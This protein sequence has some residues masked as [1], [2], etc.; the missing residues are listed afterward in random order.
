M[1][2]V[3]LTN[4]SKDYG[5]KPL[6]SELT[7]HIESKERLGII[8]GNGA[9]KSTLLNIIA[10]K[11]PLAD[12]KR[13]AT[14]H[15]SIELVD[16]QS[17][18]QENK[19]IL[20]Q[21]LSSC[22]K[23]RELLLKFANLSKE[24][25]NNPN[26]SLCLAEIGRVSQE[27]DESQAW[28][29][30]KQCQE[31]LNRLGIIEIH[32]PIKE[33]SGGYRKR[34]SLASALVAKP[35]LLLLDEPTNHL[36]ASAV[37]WLQ[38]WLDKYQGALVI[39]THDR[40][41]LDRVTTRMV[42]I[43]QG[44]AKIFKGNYNDFLIRKAE[45]KDSETSSEAKFKSILRKEID[46]LRQGP[47]ARSTKQKARIQRI[48]AMQSQSKSKAN[49]SLEINSISRR[50]GKLVIEAES[51][52]MAKDNSHDLIFKDFTY[53]F[54][55]EDRVGIIGPNGCG[56]SSLLDLIAGR[57]KT[58][59][60]ILRVGETIHIGYLDQHTEELN[61]GKGLERKVINFVE[62]AAKHISIN[63]YIITAS[64]L[65]ERF[66][67]P[68]A[69]QYTPIKKLSGGEKRRLILCRILIQSPN[70]LLLDEPTNDLDI[71]TLSV[72]EDFIEEFKGC[73]IIVSHD[74]YFLDRTVDRIFNFEEGTLKQYE[75]NYTEFINK[76][77]LL[78]K[79]SISFEKKKKSSKKSTY[80]E[81]KISDL[82]SFKIKSRKRSF[83]E[84]Q[85]LENLEK[86]IPKLEAKRNELEISLNKGSKD[87]AYLSTQL[88]QI[89]DQINDYEDR[90]I[91]L[92]EI[93]L[94]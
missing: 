89:I 74:R 32:R 25:E 68:I 78:N 60:G 56:K 37:E 12:G 2:L 29:L 15:L 63:N 3:S 58:T 55:P 7:L 91:E 93:E 22:G 62:E 90:W 34:V 46:W 33:L 1:N 53:S 75:G 14:S 65:L 59:N 47:K 76:N 88:A 81:T 87:S 28:I 48:A 61:R 43:D 21:V 42:E 18:F 16:Q 5:I 64:Q 72:L 41:V 80:T 40:Y 23:K 71:H 94:G 13:W 17:C 50:M 54:G 36:D 66:L 4:A 84:N 26:D 8:G 45:Q 10:G 38:Q 77:K 83:K 31:V 19:T 20:E 85:E 9:G 51:I 82:P 6:F 27:M 24:L 70:V 30:E 35:D 73:V 57:R 49:T 67:F 52:T 86:E 92:N 69:Q 11:E 79:H 39:V 44:S